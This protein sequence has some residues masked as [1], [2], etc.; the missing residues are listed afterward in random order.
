MKRRYSLLTI[1]AAFFLVFLYAPTVLLPLFSFNDN[2][3]AVFP[4]KGFTLRHYEAMAGNIAM[5]DALINSLV[6]GTIASVLTTAMS[7]PLAIGLTRRLLPASGLVLSTIMLP[8]V[9]PSIVF[10]VAFLI[11]LVRI[12]NI[13]LSLLT[14]TMAHIFL[15][16]PFSVMVL[17][18]RLDGL[19]PSLEEASSDLGETTLGTFR[20]IT[21]PLIIPGVISSLLMCFIT[22]FDEFVLAFFLSGTQPTL[23]VFL[24]GQLRFPNKLPSV[25]ALGSLILVAST[26]LVVLSEFIR[27]RDSAGSKSDTADLPI[28]ANVT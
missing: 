28:P 22:S 18:S 3:F 13:E 21:L 26:V 25:L 1:Y 4:L 19:D 2:T 23:P 17:M 12:M 27:R 6:V 5:I 14:I 10:A 24:Y 8:L 20:R 15:C 11:L 7:I 16:L 9:V